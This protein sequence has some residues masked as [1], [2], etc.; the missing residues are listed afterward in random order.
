MYTNTV[1]VDDV[2]CKVYK[3]DMTCFVFIYEK[4]VNPN[5]KKGREKRKEKNLS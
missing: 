3:N 1:L 2:D 4:I 5:K